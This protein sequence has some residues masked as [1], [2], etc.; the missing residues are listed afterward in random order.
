[1]AK[2]QYTGPELEAKGILK[3]DCAD[4]R[5]LFPARCEKHPVRNP[6]VIGVVR[7]HL[8]VRT[9]PRP[10]RDVTSEERSTARP[11]LRYTAPYEH[12][13][14]EISAALAASR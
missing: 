10:P 13:E 4:C 9:K 2:R 3:F 6:H 14:R 11:M 7:G 1:M 12:L 8:L 5:T